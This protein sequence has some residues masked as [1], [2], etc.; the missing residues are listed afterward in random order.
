M[1]IAFI[2]QIA[3]AV[4]HLERPRPQV[5]ALVIFTVAAVLLLGLLAMHEAP[6]EPPIFVP[7]GPIADVLE[8]G[9]ALTYQEVRECAMAG[10]CV[11]VGG[12]IPACNSASAD[13]GSSAKR[14]SVRS[15]RSIMPWRMS[16]SK[17]ITSFQ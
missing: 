5:A 13:A 2:T 14:N 10:V 3:I 6:F 7:P 15:W 9:A 12:A 1:L 17:L 8:H 11:S 4:V 16:A